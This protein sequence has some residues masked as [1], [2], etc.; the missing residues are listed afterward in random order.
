MKWLFVAIVLLNAAF[1]SWDSFTQDVVVSKEQPMYEPPVGETIRLISEQVP[2]V[3]NIQASAGNGETPVES[4]QQALDTVLANDTRPTENLLCPR[5]EVERAA[6]RDQVVAQL[7]EVGWN[8]QIQEVTGKRAK[9][10]LY[11]AAPETPAMATNIVK[12]LAAKSIDS[13]IIN[14]EEMKNRISLGLY[15]SQE[16]ANQARDRIQ[17]ASGYS[18][19]IFE[20]MRTVA[21]SNID[22]E[23]PVT[24]SQWQELISRLDLAKMMIKLEKNPC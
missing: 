11:I 22:V 6:E 7:K 18:V 23:A 17:K 21:L 2:V 9:Y 8:Y 15:S 3:S 1:F 13:F 12:T 10:W 16:R 19:D 4:V 20:H 5:I 24:E 14:R